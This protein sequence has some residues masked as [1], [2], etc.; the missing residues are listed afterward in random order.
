MTDQIATA[1]TIEFGHDFYNHRIQGRAHQDRENRY[2]DVPL[3][4]HVEGNLYHGGCVGGV[5]LPDE[6]TYVC[7]LY[8]WEKYAIGDGT[9]RE[10]YQLYDS[11]T[12]GFEMV[13]A[14]AKRVA[15]WLREGPTLVHCQAGLNRSSLIAAR[16]LMHTGKT[17]DEAIELL[18]KR[19][20][21]VLCNSAFET[22]LRENPLD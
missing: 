13:D 6:F 7:S 12:Q 3:V 2:F 20:A 9:H 21:V 18:R 22:W 4:S 11:E 17:A 19:S 10:E 15:G 16:A 1:E 8:P 5:R 14:I